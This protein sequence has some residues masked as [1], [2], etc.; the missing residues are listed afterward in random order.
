MDYITRTAL[1]SSLPRSTSL[2]STSRCLF[3]SSSRSLAAD[4][5]TTPAAAAPAEATPSPEATVAA[6]EDNETVYDAESGRGGKGYRAWLS[7]EGAKFRRAI[8]GKTN[9]LGEQVS[10]AGTF[11]RAAGQDLA[12]LQISAEPLSFA[13][14]DPRRRARRRCFSAVAWCPPA[15]LCAP[16]SILL[17]PALSGALADSPASPSLSPSTQPSPPCPL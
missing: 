17:I 15:S 8:P 3:S 6:N 10:L 7:G 5:P 12:R 14:F 16:L 13:A 1:R 2:S 4:S 11:Y 9:W